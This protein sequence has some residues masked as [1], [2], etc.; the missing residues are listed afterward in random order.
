MKAVDSNLIKLIAPSL[1]IGV[2]L[3]A[4]VVSNISGSVLMLIYAVLLFF[5]A[6]LFSFGKIDGNWQ[7]V[8]LEII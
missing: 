1:I 8:F 3:G 4:L 6:L 5:I 7:M 2:I